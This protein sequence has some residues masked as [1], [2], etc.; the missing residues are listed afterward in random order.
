MDMR[1]Y[2]MKIHFFTKKEGKLQ[3]LQVTKCDECINTLIESMKTW[4]VKV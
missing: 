3:V 4:G 1:K 2:H